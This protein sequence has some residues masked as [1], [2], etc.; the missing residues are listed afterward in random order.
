MSRK[1][2]KSD[3]TMNTT[4]L[5]EDDLQELSNTVKKV[6][7]DNLRDIMAQQVSIANQVQGHLNKLTTAIND[8]KD[9]VEVETYGVDPNV[10]LVTPMLVPAIKVLIQKQALEANEETSV[11]TSDN[12]AKI[13]FSKFLLEDFYIVQQ[14]A[15]TKLWLK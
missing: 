5:T 6:A 12:N 13:D 9:T 1:K 11:G 15:A 2:Q 3:K 14:V 4:I 10:P 8:I 7:Q